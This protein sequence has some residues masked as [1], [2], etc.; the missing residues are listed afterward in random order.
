MFRAALSWLVLAPAIAGAGTLIG[1][2]D[3]P[4]PPERPAVATRGFLDRSENP[5]AP[6]K[7]YSVTPELVVVLEGGET[8]MAAPQITWELVGESFA[9]PVIAVPAGSEVVI[10]DT[11]KVARTLAAQEDKQLIPAGPINPG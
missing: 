1:K 11:T 4:P 9:R 5:L 8:A 10:K 2:L 3:L 7:P 6:V